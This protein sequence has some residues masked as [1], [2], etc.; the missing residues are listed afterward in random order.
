MKAKEKAKKDKNC[1]GCT[2][3]GSNYCRE[4]YNF[5]LYNPKAK[6]LESFQLAKTEKVEE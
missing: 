4:C 6:T 3:Q 2:L 5:G 1:S